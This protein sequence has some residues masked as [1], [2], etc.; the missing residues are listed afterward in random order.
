LVDLEL[1]GHYNVQNNDKLAITREETMAAAPGTKA[2]YKIQW[3]VVSTEGVI[4]VYAG[5]EEGTI[6]YVI[7]DVLRVSVESLPPLPCDAP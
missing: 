7:D 3:T 5:G 4:D 6:D 2:A 1:S